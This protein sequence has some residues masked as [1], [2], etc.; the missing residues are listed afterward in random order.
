MPVP[1]PVLSDPGPETSQFVPRV[2]LRPAG[3]GQRLQPDSPSLTW[4]DLCVI[5]VG[6]LSLVFTVPTLSGTRTRFDRHRPI[7]RKPWSDSKSLERSVSLPRCCI[8]RWCFRASRAGAP[9]P[10]SRQT[11]QQNS[12]HTQSREEF[13]S[14]GAVLMINGAALLSGRARGAGEAADVS[15]PAPQIYGALGRRRR[16]RRLPL[17]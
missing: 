15:R 17:V 4:S 3:G 5:S 12:E 10:G 1:P 13:T 7:P 6:N 14:A 16:R 11:H 9:W 8:F 2:L